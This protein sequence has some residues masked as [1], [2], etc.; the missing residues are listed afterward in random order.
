VNRGDWA[1]KYSHVLFEDRVG[2][3]VRDCGGI[4]WEIN[5]GFGGIMGSSQTGQENSHR[6]AGSYIPFI[7]PD[8]KIQQK[9][10]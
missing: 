3:H 9:R 1:A 5:W 7:I 10:K 4:G 2:G 8:D 6:T